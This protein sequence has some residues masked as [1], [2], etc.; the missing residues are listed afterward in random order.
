MKTADIRK[1]SKKELE[2]DLKNLR[3]DLGK[4][5]FKLAA[6]K[7]ENVREIRTMKRNI[8]R[9]LTVINTKEN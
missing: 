5:L 2:K 3:E 7:L 4:L 1:K 9:I 6:N 8:A